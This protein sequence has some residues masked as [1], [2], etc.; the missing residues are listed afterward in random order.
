MPSPAWTAALVAIPVAAAAGWVAA[1]SREPHPAGEAAVAP[2]SDVELSARVERLERAFEAAKS[3]RND[4]DLVRRVEALEA[5]SDSGN[6]PAPKAADAAPAA[7]AAHSVLDDARRKQIVVGLTTEPSGAEHLGAIRSAAETV[8]KAAG[9]P[10]AEKDFAWAVGVLDRE[11]HR[12]RVSTDEAQEIAGML[13]ALPS[14]HAARPSL[15]KAVAIGWSRSER[16]GPFLALFPA[17][18]EPSL[19]QGILNAM[20]D[21]HPSPAFSE[22]VTRVIR[23]ERDAAVLATAL[24]LDRVEAAATV[25]AAPRLAEAIEARIRD[26]TLDAKMRRHAALALA[27]ASLRIP[28]TGVAALRRIAERDAD[29]KVAETCRQA[30]TSLE[31]GDATLK[32][33]ERLFEE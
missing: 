12:D 14:G 4:R 17:N 30:A 33:L 9:P 32:S 26:G 1:L 23:E 19:H 29:A 5:R 3:G 18:A 16:L 15:A 7:A 2:T 8:V 22:Y 28:E 24:G 11:S 31:R 13:A 25:M 27:V 6:A 20:D 10:L 21:E